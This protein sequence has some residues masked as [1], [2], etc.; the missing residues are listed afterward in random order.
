[1]CCAPCWRCAIGHDLT[2]EDFNEEWLAG[3]AAAE[4]ARAEAARRARRATARVLSSA[5]CDA[6]RR[7]LEACHWNVSAVAVRLNL[8]RK[9]IYRKMHRHGLLRHAP[10]LGRAVQESD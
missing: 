7:T 9:T 6:L 4:A 5:E 8:S 2:L 1:M 10:H 3:A